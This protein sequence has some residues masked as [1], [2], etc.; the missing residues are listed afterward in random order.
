MIVSR[1]G[2]PNRALTVGDPA[3]ME[4]QWNADWQVNARNRFAREILRCKNHQVRPTSIKIVS[5]GHDIAFVFAGAERHGS[6][7]GFA[8]RAV[9]ETVLLDCTAFNV[10]FEQDI[11]RR[12]APR[13]GRGDHVI[14]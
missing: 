8:R 1:F 11:A 7:H 5:I 13:G 9:L 6:K 12:M 2:L 4:P 3:A 10:M 14:L